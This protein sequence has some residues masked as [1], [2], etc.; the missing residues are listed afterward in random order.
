MLCFL[1]GPLTDLSLPLHSL[2][3]KVLATGT[4]PPP[5]KETESQRVAAGTEVASLGP[6]RAEPAHQA[7]GTPTPRCPGRCDPRAPAMFGD[8]VVWV[9]RPPGASQ[10][11]WVARPE[12]SSP[13]SR[14][15]GSRPPPSPGGY[16]PCWVVVSGSRVLIAGRCG[17]RPGGP[18]QGSRSA[19]PDPQQPG[20][21]APV[22][23]SSAR[24]EGRGSG[25]R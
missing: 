17:A 15:L 25:P 9:P 7:R 14:P 22:S 18:W 5:H 4:S 6:G 24:T 19:A 13:P 20:E 8:A 1:S 11:P 12:L 3:G 16:S 21:A 2:R 10:S 23:H